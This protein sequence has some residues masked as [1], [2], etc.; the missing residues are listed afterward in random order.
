MYVLSTFAG[1]EQ[2]ASAMAATEDYFYYICTSNVI[3]VD[4]NKNLEVFPFDSN[5]NCIAADKRIALVGC[6]DGTYYTIEDGEKINQGE[7]GDSV[8]VCAIL[9][10]GNYILFTLTDTVIKSIKNN[11]LIEEVFGYIACCVETVGNVVFVGSLTGRIYV[12]ECL[13]D[14]IELLEIVDAHPERINSMKKL[15]NHRLASGSEDSNI[16]IWAYNGRLRHIQTLNGHVDRIN[17]LE[18]DGTFLYSASSDKTVKVWEE[19]DSPDSEMCNETKVGF[20]NSDIIGGVSEFLG[21]CFWKDAIFAQYRTGGIEKYTRSHC[22]GYYECQYFISGHT[23]EITDL[24]WRYDLLLSSSLD[25]TTRIFYKG[26]EVGRPQIHGHPTVSAKFL[27]IGR[28]GFVSVAQ[29]TIV[30]VFETTQTFFQ[31]CV[32]ADKIG[33]S[34]YCRPSVYDYEWAEFYDEYVP[35]AILTELHLTNDVIP[36]MST[37]S[38]SEGALAIS[39]FRETSKIYGHYFELKSVAVS[40]ELILSCNKSQSKKYAGLFVWNEESENF[41]YKTDHS[42]GIQRVVAVKDRVLTVSRDKTACLYRIDESSFKLHHLGR[43]SDHS[44]VIWDG[45]ISP[46]LKYFATCS[47]DCKVILYSLNSLEV[48]NIREFYCE[49]KAIDFSP[50]D[51]EKLAVGL[52]DGSVKLLNLNLEELDEYSVLGKPVNA[53]KYSEDGL[54]LAVGGVDGVI[55]ILKVE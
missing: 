5:V 24:D 21:V 38:L 6:V 17:R 14:E 1:C 47:R 19:E 40:G 25:S 41:D 29:E 22:R 35:E 23:S 8:Q 3:R 39:V 16:K 20:R 43:F 13:E 46:N 31:R 7:L 44:R 27:Q 53:V 55:R 10:S 49:V 9:A 37:L 42:L 48:L 45:G 50:V 4:V 34:A 28:L 15:S 52:I 26:L 54:K 32:E 2:K 18:W 12:Y 11:T 36:D 33:N 51:D 30:R